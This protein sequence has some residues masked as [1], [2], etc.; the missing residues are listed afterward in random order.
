V[1]VYFNIFAIILSMVDELDLN[2]PTEKVEQNNINNK[3]N[4]PKKKRRI[5]KWIIISFVILLLLSLVIFFIALVKTNLNNLNSN[6]S[7][8]YDISTTDDPYAGGADADIVIVELADF[9]CPYCFTVFPTVRE[10]IDIYDD[11]IRFIF[12][13]FP[14]DDIH[15]Q[16]QKA[17]EAGECAS[18]Q[19]KFWEYHDKLFINQDNLGEISLI[20]YAS[21]LGLD[22]LQFKECLESNRYYE[23][24]QQDFASGILAGSE[25]TPTFFINNVEFQGALTI[26]S[27]KSIIDRLLE[28]F[29]EEE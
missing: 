26:E 4:K 29:A 28:I 23:E 16:A 14:I 18:E 5:I 13:D 8:V 15:P 27:F 12:R 2:A 6:T 24:V 7:S 1:V 20:N 10:L 11:Q 9:Q 19:G 22:E 21:E 17:A 25:G 3:G